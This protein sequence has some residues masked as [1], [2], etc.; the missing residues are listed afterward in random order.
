MV[1][2][3]DIETTKLPLK[4][5]DAETDQIMMISYMIDGQVNRISYWET[6]NAFVGILLL[7]L[8]QGLTMWLIF[9]SYTWWSSYLSRLSSE[10]IGRCSYAQITFMFLWSSLKLVS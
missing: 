8:R 10:I 1:L 6:L 4:F 9:A 5:P 7:F 2:A 3:F